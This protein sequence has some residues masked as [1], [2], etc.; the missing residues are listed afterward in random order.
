[1]CLGLCK[2][3]PLSLEGR[4]VRSHRSVDSVPPHCVATRNELGL[5]QEH[6]ASFTSGPPLQFLFLIIN[7]VLPSFYFLPLFWG[8][9]GS[10]PGP[11]TY[12]RWVLYQQAQPSVPFHCLSCNRESWGFN[13]WLSLWSDINKHPTLYNAKNM[14]KVNCP[15][16]DCGILTYHQ[17]LGC[18]KLDF[19]PASYRPILCWLWWLQRLP[20]PSSSQRDPWFPFCPVNTPGFTSFSVTTIG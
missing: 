13:F 4:R 17:L 19:H 9:W 1:M 2:W 18:I 11:V 14:P 10:N 20:H 6:C 12:A 16:S 15:V 5:L 7:M 8:F 3:L